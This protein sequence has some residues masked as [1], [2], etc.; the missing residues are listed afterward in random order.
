M[1][2]EFP[3]NSDGSRF[4]EARLHPETCFGNTPFNIHKPSD[5]ETVVKTICEI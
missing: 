4:A 5:N 2:R 1:K 3:D